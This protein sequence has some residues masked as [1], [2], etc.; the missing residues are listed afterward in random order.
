MFVQFEDVLKPKQ[1]TL[2][3]SISLNSLEEARGT[4]VGWIKGEI[5]VQRTEFERLLDNRWPF[6]VAC[7]SAARI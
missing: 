4:E 2:L 7:I 6:A 5:W 1:F 3:R